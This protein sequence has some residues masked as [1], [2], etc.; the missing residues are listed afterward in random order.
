MIGEFLVWHLK[1]GSSVVRRTYICQDRSAASLSC[2]CLSLLVIA[3]PFLSFLVPDPANL[4][5]RKVAH[6]SNLSLSLC[7]SLSL[8]LFRLA[9]ALDKFS[10]F[11][12]T[13]IWCPNSCTRSP[14]GPV[15]VI[16]VTSMM[17]AW[18][19]VSLPSLLSGSLRPLAPSFR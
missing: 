14:P 17:A 2:H 10:F 12:H 7:V 6:L 1:L 19:F 15:L 18:V 5:G 8:T 3:C 4:L 11:Y 13:A 16:R 9:R